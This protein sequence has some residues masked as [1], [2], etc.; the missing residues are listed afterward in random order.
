MRK[1]RETGRACGGK[2]TMG[3]I[4][5][6]IAVWA[7]LVLGHGLSSAQETPDRIFING[8]IVTVDDYFSIQEAVAVLGRHVAPAVL[9][10]ELDLQLG[11]RGVQGGQA[12]LRVHDFEVDGRADVAG[13]DLARPGDVQVHSTRPARQGAE[14]NGLDPLDQAK[15]VVPDVGDGGVLVQD[16][17]DADPGDGG[18]GDGAQQHAPQGGA[19]GDAEPPLQRLHGELAVGPLNLQDLDL[20][21]GDGLLRKRLLPRPQGQ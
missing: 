3:T 20:Y 17:V 18:A 15:H 7:L 14:A 13:E 11:V 12:N 10:V 16:A 5:G 2:F 4:R 6:L 21:P 8:K 9:H 19:Q 1:I